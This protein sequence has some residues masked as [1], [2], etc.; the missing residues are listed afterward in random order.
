MIDKQFFTTKKNTTLAKKMLSISAN[1]IPIVDKIV[2]ISCSLRPFLLCHHI[3]FTSDFEFS[4]VDENLDHRI[5]VESLKTS[6]SF[7]TYIHEDE[8]YEFKLFLIANRNSEGVLLPELLNIDYIVIPNMNIHQD[9]IQNLLLTLRN[10]SEV[11]YVVELETQK[12]KS[13]HNLYID[14]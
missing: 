4:L 13:K 6:V 12:L 2:G 11:S 5:F 10:I 7:T 8:E 9:H 3:N 14:Q 1:D